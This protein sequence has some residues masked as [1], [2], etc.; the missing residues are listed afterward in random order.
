MVCHH[1]DSSLIFLMFFFCFFLFFNHFQANWIRKY[2]KI[3]IRQINLDGRQFINV[4]QKVNIN[5]R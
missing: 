3:R 5:T 2:G 4:T 1:G